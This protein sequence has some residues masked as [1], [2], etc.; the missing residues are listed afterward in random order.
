MFML[1]FKIKM[2]MSVLMRNDMSMCYSIMGMDDCM[3]MFMRVMLYHSVIHNKNCTNHHKHKT[4]KVY[5]G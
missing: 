2:I 4:Y 1:F 3:R 5:Y